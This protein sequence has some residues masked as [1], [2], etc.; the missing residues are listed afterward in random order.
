MKISGQKVILRDKTLLD[1]H[2][3]Y[4]W[5]RDPEL[6]HLDA[7]PML[8]LTFQEFL[9]DFAYEL[10]HPSSTNRRFA[11][12]T[13]D[14]SHIGNC[15][16]YNL[17]RSRNEAELGILIGNRAY[18]SKGYGTD[19][20]TTLLDYLFRQLNLKR[21]HLK[22]LH[23]NIRAQKSFRKSGF[24]PYSRATREGYDFLLM[25]ITSQ[26]W[27]EMAMEKEAREPGELSSL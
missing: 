15:G 18:W 22:T 19:T 17:D 5:Q 27:D 16:Y 1:A 26:R 3:N 10:H 23:S 21:V 13:L 2:D 11:I 20:V 8:T 9:I 7:A 6:V 25:E 14:G 12:E 4:S 24:T